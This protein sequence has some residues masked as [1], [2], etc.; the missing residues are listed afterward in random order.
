MIGSIKNPSDAAFLVGR[1]RD[2]TVRVEDDDLRPSRPVGLTAVSGSGNATLSWTTGAAGT[3]PIT[4]YE[5]R[6]STDSGDTWNPDWTAIPGSSATT[7]SYVVTGLNNQTGYY[8]GVR[9]V[10]DAGKG[11]ESYDGVGSFST[12]VSLH[13]NGRDNMAPWEFDSGKRVTYEGGS[14]EILTEYVKW[15][16]PGITYLAPLLKNDVWYPEEDVLGYE[17]QMR[18]RWQAEEEGLGDPDQTWSS[19][20]ELIDEDD[21]SNVKHHTELEWAQYLSDQVFY[22]IEWPVRC[23]Q[24]EWRVRA[25]YWD[26]ARHSGWA[27]TDRDYRPKTNSQRWIR[28]NMVCVNQQPALRP[29]ADPPPFWPIWSW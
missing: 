24:R 21:N 12:P 20:E 26:P 28:E 16:Q 15:K 29:G 18:S 2:F 10:S 3:S 14:L 9:A 11:E 25:I 6:Q 4:G 7:T 5:Y 23:E 1:A 17:V 22:P 8:F 27:Y 19:W 13:Q